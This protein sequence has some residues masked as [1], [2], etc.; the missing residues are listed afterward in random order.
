MLYYKNLRRV[1]Y[2]NF[3]SLLAKTPGAI[4]KVYGSP[5]NPDLEGIVK[6]YET[7]LGAIVVAQVTGLPQTEGAC[8]H[9]VF[10]FHIHEGDACSG[11]SNDFFASALTH[12]NPDGC[13]HPYHAGDMPPL[14][15]AGGIAF[16]AFLT[17]RFSVREII[18]K[19][20]IIHNS[21]DDFS[22]QPSG[23]AGKKIACGVIIQSP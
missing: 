1:V 7:D 19:T 3:S 8:S 14:L 2:L 18:G 9:G 22:T 4:A 17:D 20:V 5:D 12:Y 13:P 21:P 10:A 15:G 16:T 11:D 23:N 6:F